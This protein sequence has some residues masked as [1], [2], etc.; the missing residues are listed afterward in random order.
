MQRIISVILSILV[1][2]FGTLVPG[3][4]KPVEPITQG[5]WLSMV[6]S[7]FGMDSYESSTP[8]YPNVTPDNEYFGAVQIAYEWG[9]ID[10]EDEIDVDANVTSEFAVKTLVRVANLEAKEDGPVIKNADALKYADEI[11]IAAANDI[12]ELRANNTFKVCDMAYDAAVKLLEKVKDNWANQ[13][14]DE[15]ADY[16]VKYTKAVDEVATNDYVIEDNKVTFAQD[17]NVSKGETIVL[18]R[19]DENVQGAIMSV[20]SV[21]SVDGK[22]VIEATPV[23]GQ[24]VIDSVKFKGEVTPNLN[25][26]KI[27]DAQGNVIQTA[28]VDDNEGALGDLIKSKLS[29][30]SFNIGPV[31]IGVALKDNGFDISASGN[32]CDGVNLADTFSVKNLNVQ[33]KL[34]ASIA[35]GDIKEAYVVLDYDAVNT[36]TV[37]GAQT[38]GLIN[39]STEDVSG[40]GILDQIKA[41]FSNMALKAGAF[42]KINVFSV[43]IPI[44]NCPEVTITLDISL[45]ITVSGR[46][47]LVITSHNYNGY[48]IINNKGRFIHESTENHNTFNAYGSAEATGCISVGLGILTY[49]LIDVAINAGIGVFVMTTITLPSVNDDPVQVCEELPTDMVA[50]AVAVLDD[51]DKFDI[52]GVAQ[53]YGVLSISVGK[54]SLMSKIGLSKTWNIF[55]RSNGVFAT[56]NF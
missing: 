41:N 16:E 3:L 38:W 39:Q 42:S 51:A 56:I 55:D 23:D 20:D 24:D 50:Q 9:V 2:F 48:E 46:A 35:Q 26:S 25:A 28:T 37:T 10:S 31:A 13:K 30:F 1:L 49:D 22:T 8:Y 43:A 32:V 34:D 18:P 4:A 14:F 33:T 44:P 40:L 52:A 27:T 36:T 21:E 12:I 7:E 54:N 5:E 11:A 15:D 47:E 6:D 19:N 45:Q 53:F 17:V 29:N